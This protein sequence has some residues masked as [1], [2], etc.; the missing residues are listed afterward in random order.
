MENFC[1]CEEGRKQK[2]KRKKRG[3]RVRQAA[4]WKEEYDKKSL[5]MKVGLI[6][7][8]GLHTKKKVKGQMHYFAEYIL[9]TYVYVCVSEL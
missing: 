3:G 8:W 1:F 9:C 5:V 4:L 2:R 6:S 7:I